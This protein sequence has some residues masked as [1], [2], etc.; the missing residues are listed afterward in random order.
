MHHAARIAPRR[1]G[2]ALASRN[3][4][5][6][7]TVSSRNVTLASRLSCKVTQGHVSVTFENK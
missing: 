7:V 2:V 1:A 3:V 5:Q 4:T 6:Y